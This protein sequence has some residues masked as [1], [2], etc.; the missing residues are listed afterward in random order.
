[1][2]LGM[3]CNLPKTS[4]EDD[5]IVGDQDGRKKKQVRIDDACAASS[6]AGPSTLAV[7]IRYGVPS[8]SSAAPPPSTSLT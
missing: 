3:T 4:F 8:Y 5:A 6:K 7:V 1:M 2:G